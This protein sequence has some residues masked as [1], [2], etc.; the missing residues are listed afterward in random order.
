[1]NLT[2]GRGSLKGTLLKSLKITSPNQFLCTDTTY[3]PMPTGYMYLAAIMD[4]Y[5]RIVIGWDLSNTLDSAFCVEMLE[6]VLTKAKPR[7]FNTDQEPCSG[8][9][10]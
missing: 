3:I 9:K 7:I 8:V 2:P 1:M 5:S 4:C 10:S 6:K